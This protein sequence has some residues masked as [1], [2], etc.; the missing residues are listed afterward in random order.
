MR[1][2]IWY[3]YFLSLHVLAWGDTY[4]KI[5]YF[6]FTFTHYI[7]FWNFRSWTWMFLTRKSFHI[8]RRW[9]IPLSLLVGTEWTFYFNDSSV[10]RNF[11]ANR[12]FSF[13]SC[14]TLLFFI[15]YSFISVGYNR[16]VELFIYRRYR[17]DW[18][19]Y[20]GISWSTLTTTGVTRLTRF[21]HAIYEPTWF[22]A[23]IGVRAGGRRW[24]DS[25]KW[26][27]RENEVS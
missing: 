26:E 24:C 16:V 19:R 21:G 27:A 7:A 8:I 20:H 4:H 5:S 18:N 12:I 23:T 6:R 1:S 17:Y 25:L 14:K 15:C 9:W 11:T 22:G 3:C 2:V 10:Y 13:Y